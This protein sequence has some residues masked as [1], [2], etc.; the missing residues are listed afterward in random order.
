M[1]NYVGGKKRSRMRFLLL[2]EILNKRALVCVDSPRLSPPPP[3]QIC[4]VTFCLLRSSVQHLLSFTAG[5]HAR[6]SRLTARGED[7][8]W[9]HAAW[10]SI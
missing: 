6:F 5:V 10:L 7:P 3:E 1:V 9:R 8:D 4:A 2:V